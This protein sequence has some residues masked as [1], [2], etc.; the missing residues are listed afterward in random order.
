M[1][2]RQIASTVSTFGNGCGTPFEQ[3]G[4]ILFN[5]TLSQI[6]LSGFGKEEKNVKKNKL[7]R[8]PTIITTT[9]TTENHC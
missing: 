2:F 7:T 8:T 3:T 6:W 1:Y 5:D 4:I 9:Q